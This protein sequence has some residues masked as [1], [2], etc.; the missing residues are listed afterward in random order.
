LSAAD[1]DGAGQSARGDGHDGGCHVLDVQEITDAVAGHEGDWLVSQQLVD[2]HRYQSLRILERSVLV[3][4]PHP[5]RLT[6][7]GLK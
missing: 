6:W 7:Q 4:K 3:E 2:H 5:R 1:V